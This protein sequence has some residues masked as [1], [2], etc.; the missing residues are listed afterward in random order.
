MELGGGTF[1]QYL[2]YERWYCIEYSRDEGDRFYFQCNT[3]VNKLT[4]HIV[5]PPNSRIVSRF[6]K[7]ATTP[8]FSVSNSSVSEIPYHKNLSEFS[9]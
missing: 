7:V 3:A 4:L 5:K 2:Q 9:C 1:M 8:T 6:Q